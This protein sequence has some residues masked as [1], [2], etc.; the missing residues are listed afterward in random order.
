MADK[1]LLFHIS[2]IHFGLEDDR[3]L[4]WLVQEIA[5]KRPAAVAITGD[6]TMRARH[7]EFAAACHWIRSLDVPVT[8]EVGNHDLPYF[9]LIERFTAPY[10]RFH[11]IEALV[12]RKLELP[13]L[14]IVSLKTVRRWQPRWPWSH[15]WVTDKALE[16]ALAAIDALPPGTA[17]VVACHHPLVEAG[18]HGK[19]WTRGGDRALA[20]LARRGVLATLSGHVHDAFDIVSQTP[21]GPVRMIGAGTLSQRIRSTPQSFNEI[22]WDGERLDVRVRS[23]ADVPT[24]AMQVAEVPEDALPP[25]EPDEPVAPVGTVPR[26]D[27]PVH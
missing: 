24:P 8:V 6:L 2:D 21:H 12:E 7:R 1:T 9:N 26:V 14:A 25:R 15:G 11:A 13:G 16:R 5:E 20:E 3:S 18:T 17:V 4:D 22:T 19:A 10:R 23:I 27:P